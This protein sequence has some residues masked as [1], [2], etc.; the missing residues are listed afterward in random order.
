MQDSLEADL[1]A[2]HL[3][4]FA[5]DQAAWTDAYM[6]AMSRSDPLAEPRH[7]EQAARSAWQSH[8]W[9]HPAVVA[10]LEHTLGPLDED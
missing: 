4:P 5:R 8:G 2:A 6:T 10:H 7:V 9:A 1:L 3:M